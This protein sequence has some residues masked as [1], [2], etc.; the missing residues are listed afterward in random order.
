M[1]RED[2]SKKLRSLGITEAMEGA[3]IMPEYAEAMDLVDAG[4]DIFGRP[5]KMTAE[6]YAAWKQMRTS[7]AQDSIELKLVSAH[8]SVDYQCDLIQKKIEEGRD[9]EDIL[10]VNAMPGHSEHHTGRALDLHAGDDTPLEESFENHPAFD[11]L[12]THAAS[13]GFRM[14]YPKDNTA[15]IDYEP[16]HWCFH[17]ET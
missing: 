7:A 9:I 12:S 1:N 15:G 16:W 5:Q 17:P 8:R 11:W 3:C 10:C 14:S 6:T 2:L 4:E 13:F